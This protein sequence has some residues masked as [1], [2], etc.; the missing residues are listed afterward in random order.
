M[1]L[2]AKQIEDAAKAICN[3]RELCGNEREAFNDWAAD[4]GIAPELSIYKE[5]NFR[6]AQIWRKYQISAGVDLKHVY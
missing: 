6:A 1:K 4:N 5:A 2:T 3:S